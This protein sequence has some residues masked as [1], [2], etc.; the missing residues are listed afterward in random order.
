MNALRSA[1][2]FLNEVKAE[3][4]KITWPSKEDVIGTVIIVCFLTV[5]FAVL[6][7]G[8]DFAFGL[9]IRKILAA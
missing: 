7:G 2:T 5:I 1:I 8:M 3:I 9:L 6:L 4:F